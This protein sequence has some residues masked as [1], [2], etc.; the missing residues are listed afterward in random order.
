M[1]QEI[2]LLP[3]RE[4]ARQKRRRS[5]FL[6]L[7]GTAAMTVVIVGGAYQ[8]F[9]Q[10][11]NYQYARNDRVQQEITILNRTL[12]EFSNKKV[13]RD[14]LQHRLELVNALQKQRN[15]PTLLFN[16]LPDV[17]PEGVVLD[18]VSMYG[19]TVSIEGRSKSN[20][21][22][23]NLLA[24]LEE[25]QD[26]AQVQMHSIVNKSDLADF[27]ANQFRAT[28]QLTAYVVPELPTEENNGV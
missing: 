7:A 20:A 28:F 4:M 27:A 22:L 11:L 2:N 3:W 25:S 6:K 1:R 5:F 12:R 17:M 24:K 15:N 14:K 13:A 19:K 26:V 8:W 21:Q 18:K 10:Q 9:D 23:A 16:I